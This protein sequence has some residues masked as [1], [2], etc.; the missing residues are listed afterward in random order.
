MNQFF[1]IDLNTGKATV[2]QSDRHDLFGMDP[3]GGNPLVVVFPPVQ[4]NMRGN[5]TR[6]EITIDS[7]SRAE[8]RNVSKEERSEYLSKN[9]GVSDD[10]TSRENLIKQRLGTDNPVLDR[11]TLKGQPALSESP[12]VETLSP[13]SNILQEQVRPNYLGTASNVAQGGML[14]GNL[15]EQMAAEE[16]M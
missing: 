1:A 15:A 11:R 6:N 8:Q 5:T 7:K 2:V 13:S 10:L 12:V 16:Q 9:F 3:L 14:M 4:Y